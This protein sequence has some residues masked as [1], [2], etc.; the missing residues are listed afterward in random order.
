MPITNAVY[1]VLYEN[2]K[3]SEELVQLMTRRL[4]RE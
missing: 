1:N 4:R 2:K 3:P